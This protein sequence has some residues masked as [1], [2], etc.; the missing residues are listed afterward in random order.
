MAETEHTDE[1]FAEELLAS[2]REDEPEM[3]PEL[4]DRTIRKV[5]SL[6]TT[7]DLVDLTTVVF[8]LQFCAPLIDLIAAALGVENPR[9]DE[10]QSND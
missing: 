3:P 2:L 8:L 4:P 1:E 7:R 10:G 6:M 9:R 5:Q